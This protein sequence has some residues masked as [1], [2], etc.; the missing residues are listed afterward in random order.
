MKRRFTVAS[1]HAKVKQL[2]SERRLG[3]ANY[4]LDGGKSR[5]VTLKISAANR[6]LLRRARKV[7]VRAF[8][9]TTDANGNVGNT[10]RAATLRF[11]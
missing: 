6:R 10:S 9:V 5:T 1:S 8:A 7:K 4:R 2:R 11:S 3:R